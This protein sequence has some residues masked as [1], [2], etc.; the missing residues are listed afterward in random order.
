[1]GEN[2]LHVFGLHFQ[3][4]YGLHAQASPRSAAQLRSSVVRLT[5][6]AGAPVTLLV[7]LFSQLIELS[8]LPD[9]SFCHLSSA[10]VLTKNCVL[11]A[12][13]IYTVNLW[14]KY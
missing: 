14:L 5:P 2:G 11:L 4:V 3:L 12:L 6:L 10:D 9:A 8:W 1:M 13:G 7:W